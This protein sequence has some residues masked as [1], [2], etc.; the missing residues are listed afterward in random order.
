MAYQNKP[1]QG[2][3][4]PNDQQGNPARPTWRGSVNINGK[5]YEISAWDKTSGRGNRYLS[6]DVREPRPMQQQAPYQQAPQQNAPRQQAPRPAP[7]PHPQTQYAPQPSAPA[8]GGKE[9]SDLPFR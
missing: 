6:L 3:M 7:Q 9:P 1:G 4:F 5:E 2:V 8:Q